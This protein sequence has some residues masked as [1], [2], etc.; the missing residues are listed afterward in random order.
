MRVERSLQSGHVD[1]EAQQDQLPQDIASSSHLLLQMP[2]LKQGML[3]RAAVERVK[4]LNQDQR[5]KTHA[6][7]FAEGP[8]RVG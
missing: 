6:L 2:I 4:E 8:P 3:K 5:D 1:Y 7:G